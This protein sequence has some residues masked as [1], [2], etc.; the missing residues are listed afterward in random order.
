MKVFLIQGAEHYINL[1]ESQVSH[2]ELKEYEEYKKSAKR[3]YHPEHKVFK[4]F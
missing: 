2:P 1:V 3:L 4:H